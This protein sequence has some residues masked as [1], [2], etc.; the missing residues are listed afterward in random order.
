MCIGIL[1]CVLQYV[2]LGVV[3]VGIIF[4]G[5]AFFSFQL[6]GDIT[7]SLIVSYVTTVR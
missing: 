1:D 3:Y 6:E 2:M 5:Q 7:L 4:H